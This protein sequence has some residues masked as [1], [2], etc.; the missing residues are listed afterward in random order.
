MY[1]LYTERGAWLSN[2]S[3]FLLTFTRSLSL[4]LHQFL[5]YSQCQFLFGQNHLWIHFG[6]RLE[7]NYYKRI[8][9]KSNYGRSLNLLVVPCLWDNNRPPYWVYDIIWNINH[10]SGY[11]MH[12][13]IKKYI[14]WY[15]VNAALKSI[16]YFAGT[17]L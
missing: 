11:Y 3:R 13:K 6:F 4:V 10:G 14:L 2:R 8:E 15:R 12:N 17:Y 9:K 1:I 5:L 7:N 16:K